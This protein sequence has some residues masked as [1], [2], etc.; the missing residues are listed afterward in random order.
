MKKF[1]RFAM[2]VALAL[3]GCALLDA[4]DYASRAFMRESDP[5]LAKDAFPTM[6]KAAEAIQLADP[7][8]Q[9]AA[10]LVAS[11]YVMYANAFLDG[12]A[13]LLPDEAFEERLGLARRANA[14]YLR[15]AALLAPFV[16]A[17][18]PGA[19][20][21]AVVTEDPSLARLGKK[22]VPT[23]YWAAAAILA[24]FASDP[25]DFDNAARVSGALALFERARTVEPDWNGGALHELAISVYGSLPT[26]LGGDRAKARA[27]FELAKAASSA[28]SPG[29]FVAYASSVCAPEGDADGFAQALETALGLPDRPE[30]ALMDAIARRKARRL[31]DDKDLYFY[32]GDI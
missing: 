18:A 3:Q 32:L 14:L 25:M 7:D 2:A 17:R 26:E 13:F 12:E 1:M 23:L 15:A 19:L 20:G 4:G 21:L 31:L 29:A 30:S 10:T 11:L 8:D 5:A 24:A 9:G 27:A 16:E 22:D 28:S 6:I